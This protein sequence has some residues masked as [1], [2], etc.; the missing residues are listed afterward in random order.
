MPDFTNY[1]FRASAIH[2]LMTQPQSKADRDAGNISATTKTYLNE[3]YR[4]VKYG[5]RA[6]FESKYTEKGKV[7][8]ENA[9]T[10]YSRIKGEFYKKN[11]ERIN[12][13]YTTGEPDTFLGES[14]MK[15]EEGVDIKC[16]WSLFTFP[17]PGDKLSAAYEWQGHDYIWLTGAKKWT[18]AFCL[19]NAPANL[20]LNEKKNV[21][22]KMDMPADNDPVYLAKCMDIEK[23]MIF[24]IGEFFEENPGFDLHCTDWSF[25]I[26]IKERLV[27]YEVMRDDNC[28]DRIVSEAVKARK[29][30]NNIKF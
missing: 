1:L 15:C 9:I 3:I 17:Y 2:K 18:T 23:N 24:D 28:I 22:Y 10:L 8:E 29:Y 27:E 11:T 5:R 6:E 19:M 20:I 16:S 26:P 25:D 14:I 21:W 12:N 7:Q 30:L 4:E 13:E